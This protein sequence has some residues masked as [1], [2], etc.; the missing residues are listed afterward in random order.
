MFEEKYGF[1]FTTEVS[2]R[3]LK[4]MIGWPLLLGLL[5]YFA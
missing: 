4:H 3:I 2:N 1:E 5:W